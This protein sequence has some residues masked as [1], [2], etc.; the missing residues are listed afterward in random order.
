MSELRDADAEAV[1]V[2]A[3]LILRPHPRADVTGNPERRSGYWTTPN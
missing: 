3:V 1:A 2:I